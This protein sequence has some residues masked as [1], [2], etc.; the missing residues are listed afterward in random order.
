MLNLLQNKEKAAAAEGKNS[1]AACDVKIYGK[2]SV[3][4]P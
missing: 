3:F 1:V 4:G 2:S